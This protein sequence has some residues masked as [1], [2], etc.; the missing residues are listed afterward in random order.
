ME[1]QKTASNQTCHREILEKMSE[2][3]NSGFTSKKS[4]KNIMETEILVK[5]LFF[6]LAC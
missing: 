5:L 2:K 6:P 4:R 1:D 3:A